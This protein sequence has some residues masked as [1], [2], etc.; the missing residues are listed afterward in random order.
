MTEARKEATWL[1]GLLNE[2][3]LKQRLLKVQCDSQSAMSCEESGL[4]YKDETH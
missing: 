2:M 3:G 4:S 1:K